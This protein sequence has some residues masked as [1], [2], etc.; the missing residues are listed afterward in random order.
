MSD[1][2]HVNNTWKAYLNYIANTLDIILVEGG[3]ISN[4][5]QSKD[6]ADLYLYG[7]DWTL[8]GTAVV[9]VDYVGGKSFLFSHF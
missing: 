5:T 4:E 1:I 3:S 9:T 7:P 2:C 6:Y 8:S